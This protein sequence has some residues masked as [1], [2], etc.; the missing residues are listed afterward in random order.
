MN[1][2]NCVIL[3]CE[4][5][6]V[7]FKSQCAMNN[8]NQTKKHLDKVNNNIIDLNCGVCCVSFTSESALNIHNKTKKHLNK[9]NDV[10]KEELECSLCKVNFLSNSAYE[11]HNKTKKH[12]DNVMK[13]D[14]DIDNN[15][16]LMCD[17]KTND[18]SNMKKHIKNIHPDIKIKTNKSTVSKDGI[19]ENTLNLYCNLVIKYDFLKISIMGIKSRIN[20]LVNRGEEYFKKDIE[21]SKQNYNNKLIEFNKTGE[22]I[23]KMKIKFNLDSDKNKN[24]IQTKINK[25][26]KYD[27]DDDDEETDDDDES[28]EAL[29]KILKK[30]DDKKKEELK[31]KELETE[32]NKLYDERGLKDSKIVFLVNKK[33]FSSENERI[34]ID[35][36]IN[37]LLKEIENINDSICKL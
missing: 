36:E 18:K 30:N 33:M 34:L 7:S 26:Q 6:G 35:T 1:C 11:A 24:Q 2:E 13:T 14:F 12:L 21:E 5:C 9:I 31:I 23:E 20:R 15:C 16:C 25:I 10:K 17:Y 27:I 19:D 37:T 22:T 28:D 3:N 32:K 29:L 4:F 8:H